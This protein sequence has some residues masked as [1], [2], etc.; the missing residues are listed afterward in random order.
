MTYVTTAD[1][2]RTKLEAEVVDPLELAVQWQNMDLVPPN[3]DVGSE[4]RWISVETAW[5]S[6]EWSCKGV[7]TLRGEF[8]VACMIPV[9]R[10]AGEAQEIA[11]AVSASFGPAFVNGLVYREPRIVRL[12][13]RGPWHVV[14]AVCPFEDPDP[15][16][17]AADYGAPAYIT[18]EQAFQVVRSRIC[19]ELEE[20][21]DITVRYDNDPRLRPAA[22]D[23]WV[24]PIITFVAAERLE[25]G[26]GGTS[27]GVG[28]VRAE[29]FTQAGIGDRAGLVIGD[30]IVS[31]FRDVADSGVQF[32][33]P[34]FRH[35]GRRQSSWLDEVRIPFR[36]TQ[37]A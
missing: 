6:A 13:R 37:A 25:M 29:I 10:L 15:Y 5:D 22:D 7:T 16:T 9:G 33:T 17:P 20:D 11:Q 14:V 18:Q 4:E 2:L 19:R 27:D 1:K 3:P 21:L 35:V 31:K 23:S 26:P 24:E 34:S 12:G 8:Q 36:I 30:Q 32:G 28:S